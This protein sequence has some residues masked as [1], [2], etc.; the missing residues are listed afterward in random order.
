MFSLVFGS[1]SHSCRSSVKSSCANWYGLLRCNSMTL[2]CLVS[3]DVIHCLRWR[4]SWIIAKHL[5]LWEVALILQQELVQIR[6]SAVTQ[7]LKLPRSSTDQQLVFHRNRLLYLEHP[8]LYIK[9]VFKFTFIFSRLMKNSWI[10][11]YLTSRPMNVKWQP[12]SALILKTGLY[13][14]LHTPH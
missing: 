4:S 11:N 1:H 6:I 14:I 13:W 3:W 10:L 12:T 5:H 8:V 7:L 2:K 9:T